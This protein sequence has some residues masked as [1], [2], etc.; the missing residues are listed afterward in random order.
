MFPQPKPTVHGMHIDIAHLLEAVCGK[1]RS[2]AATA[3]QNKLLFSIFVPFFDIALEN[4][5]ANV[6]GIGNMAV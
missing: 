4:P 3:I 6:A 1:S 2:V 5:F